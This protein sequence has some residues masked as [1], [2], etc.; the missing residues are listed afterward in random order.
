MK[1]TPK[2]GSRDKLPQT[3][4]ALKPMK[5]VGRFTT[6]MHKIGGAAKQARPRSKPL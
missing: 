3:V 2:P 5:P 6:G 4:K 1:G